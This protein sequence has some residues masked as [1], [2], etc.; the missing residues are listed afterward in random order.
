MRRYSAAIVTAAAAAALVGS[1][2]AASAQGPADP[3]IPAEI[4]MDEGGQ[5]VPNAT[6]FTHFSC[7]SLINPDLNGT[8]VFP[9]A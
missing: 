3:P 8:P 7:V 4:C 1:A 5:V 6:S 9:P 2:G